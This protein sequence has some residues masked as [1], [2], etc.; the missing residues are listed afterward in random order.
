MLIKYYQIDILTEKNFQGLSKFPGFIQALRSEQGKKSKR[1]KQI[2]RNTGLFDD[3]VHDFVRFVS[4]VWCQDFGPSNEWNESNEAK[5]TFSFNL[6]EMELVRSIYHVWW[7]RLWGNFW[8]KRCIAI[9]IT[10]FL[11][12]S[13]VYTVKSCCL[14]DI[15]DKMRYSL[16]IRRYYDTQ[17][18]Y[19]SWVALYLPI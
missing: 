17:M 15:C 18:L 3:F 14:W 5:F 16:L 12:F 13:V 9:D 1:M 2:E 11:I 6:Q 10:I 4:N 7:H 19:L 8:T